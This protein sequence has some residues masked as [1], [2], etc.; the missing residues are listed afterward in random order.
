MVI[1]SKLSTTVVSNG[2]FKDS[3]KTA[4]WVSEGDNS[5]AYIVGV[6]SPLVMVVHNLRGGYV[7]VIA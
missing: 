7:T 6:Y 1:Y 5:V 2:S 3:Y 4:A